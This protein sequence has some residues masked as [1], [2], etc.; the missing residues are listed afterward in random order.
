MARAKPPS[1]EPSPFNI[2]EDRPTLDEYQKRIEQARRDRGPQ[3]ELSEDDSDSS[4]DVAAPG[5]KYRK[6]DPAVLEDMVKFEDSFK[7][8]NKRYRLIDRIGEGTG[9]HTLRCAFRWLLRAF[10][11]PRNFLDGVQ[12]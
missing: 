11:I 1:A 10:D 12:S 5:K 7:G 6:I 8:I 3:E 2:L 4:N 9:H